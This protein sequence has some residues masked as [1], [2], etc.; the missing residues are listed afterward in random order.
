MKELKKQECQKGRKTHTL[1]CYVN[2]TSEEIR[3]MVTLHSTAMEK[4]E[5]LNVVWE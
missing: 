4:T 1:L 5:S 2:F 3:I